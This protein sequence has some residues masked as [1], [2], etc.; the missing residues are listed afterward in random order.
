MKNLYNQDG[1]LS[2]QTQLLLSSRPRDVSIGAWRILLKKFR[3]ELSSEELIEFNRLKANLRNDK[4]RTANPEKFNKSCAKSYKK[5]KTEKPEIIKKWNSDYYINNTEKVTEGNKR[6]KAADPAR[7]V[8]YTVR[9]QKKR[10]AADPFFRLLSN[11]RSGCTR[12]VRQ[13]SLGKKPTNTLKWIGCSAIELKTHF[14]SLFAK[15]MHWNNYGEWE[16]D[17][18]RPVAS[19]SAEDWKKVNHYTNLQPLWA[20]DNRNKSDSWL[21][22]THTS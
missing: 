15:G 4:W 13:L 17:H 16:V 6:R 8:Q 18:I 2:V 11:L 14:E 22:S 20:A 5:I 21:Q 10:K 7:H 12:I 19:F 1:A 3:A 9:Y